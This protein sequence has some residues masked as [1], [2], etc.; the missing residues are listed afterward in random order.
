MRWRQQ[1]VVLECKVCTRNT[2]MNVS[3]LRW[4]LNEHTSKFSK[5]SAAVTQASTGKREEVE[6]AMQR[7]SFA[8]AQ[9]QR[10][11][12]DHD[13]KLELFWHRRTASGTVYNACQEAA[14]QCVFTLVHVSMPH[15]WIC[16]IR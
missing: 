3:F 10:S 7:S 11:F 8:I 6:M 9:N 1:E 12:N 2:Q 16:S 5:C 14:L 13:L 15:Y 4:L